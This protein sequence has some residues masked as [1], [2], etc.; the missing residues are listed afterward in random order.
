MMADDLDNVVLAR[1][2]E[3]R[4]KQ[5]EQ[6]TQ[7][8]EIDRR[9]VAL[10]KRVEDLHGLVVYSL[11]QG[12]ETSFKQSRQDKRIDDVFEQL[13]KLLVEKQSS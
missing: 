10:D 9:L 13:E 1:L 6:S 5:D 3:I 7:L 4:A 2:R 8:G 12:T 11:G